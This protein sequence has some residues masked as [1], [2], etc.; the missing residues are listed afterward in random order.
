MLAISFLYVP[1]IYESRARYRVYVL[2][3]VARLPAEIEK[4]FDEKIF[5]F[6]CIR[7][8]RVLFW[9]E[10]LLTININKK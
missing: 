5:S 10:N 2:E 9:N 7:F 3:G 6:H 1:H 8:A 4:H